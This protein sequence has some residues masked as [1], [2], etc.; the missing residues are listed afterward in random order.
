MGPFLQVGGTWQINQDNSHNVA[1]E[2]QQ[3]ED[4]LSAVAFHS[5][6]VKSI[7]ATGSV[8]GPHF[9]MT[10]TWDDGSK[11]FYEGDFQPGPNPFFGSLRGHTKDLNHPGSEAN[12][13]SGGIV[14]H[15]A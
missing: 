2:V 1:I 15:F 10:I 5:G 7:E 8:R 3:E 13:E 14:F 12:W 9:E 11:G 4:R 6:H